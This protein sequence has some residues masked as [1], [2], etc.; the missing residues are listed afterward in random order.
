M[1]LLVLYSRELN[2]PELADPLKKLV[3]QLHGISKVAGMGL[4]IRHSNR[5]DVYPMMDLAE[6][7]N[8]SP[9]RSVFGVYDEFA[10]TLYGMTDDV[11]SSLHFYHA[12]SLEDMESLKPVL[13]DRWSR[14]P[15][16]SL[17]SII[18]LEDV[19]IDTP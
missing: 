12:T 14:D 17:M 4:V 9:S 18:I 15:S 19:V 1:I 7:S 3:Q 5:L 6:L 11:R 13:E 16:V 10:A 2:L 8:N